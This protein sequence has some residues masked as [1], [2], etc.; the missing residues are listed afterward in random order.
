M[1]GPVLH[2]GRQHPTIART[3]KYCGKHDDT[4]HDPEGQKYIY[5]NQQ[6]PVYAHLLI[7]PQEDDGKEPTGTPIPVRRL[8]Q[9]MNAHA[10]NYTRNRVVTSELQSLSQVPQEGDDRC[11]QDLPGWRW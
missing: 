8:L 9:N 6:P 3:T 2:V 11:L 7:T 10:L 1:F 4:H 5:S